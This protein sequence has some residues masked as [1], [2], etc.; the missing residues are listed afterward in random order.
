MYLIEKIRD[1]CIIISLDL[2]N[3]TTR[4]KNGYIFFEIVF[5]TLL[6]LTICLTL[7]NLLAKKP[8]FFFFCQ[9]QRKFPRGQI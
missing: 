8:S 5:K 3:E 7:I 4:L 2:G 6:Y 1:I 9:Q